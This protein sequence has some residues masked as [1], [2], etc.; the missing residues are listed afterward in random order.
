MPSHLASVGGLLL[1]ESGMLLRRRLCSGPLLLLG[2]A[3]CLFYQTFYVARNRLRTGQQPAPCAHRSK[4][5][6]E[7]L[8]EEGRR[9]ISALETLQ[10]QVQHISE[11]PAQRRRAL[12]LT[13]QHVI[14]DTEIQLYQRV[15][16]QMDYE[17]Q[18]SRYTETS[19][20]V[21][22]KKGVSEW[23]LLLCLS[24][25]ETS[26]LR[27][28]S[29]SH[30][31]KHQRVN[32]LPGLMKAFSDAG[33]GLCHIFTHP[34]L[35][36]SKLPMRP[37]SCGP[38][39]RKHL[40]PKA[41]TRANSLTQPIAPSLTAMVNVYILVTSV[42]PLTSFLH[43]LSV[44]MTNQEQRGQLTQLKSLRPEEVGYAAS[45]Q[46]IMGHLKKVISDVLQAVAS[47]YEKDQSVKRCL[48]CY[49][50]LTFTLLFNGSL[51][52]TIIQVDTDWTFS[53]LSDDTF[54]RKITKDLMLEETLYF[55]LKSQS[56]SSSAI[57]AMSRE[58][59]G[60]Q[61]TF[62]FCLS[63]EDLLLPLQFNQQ[64]KLP[65]AFNLLNP[66]TPLCSTS[67]HPHNVSDLLL[68][69][70]C[71][72]ELQRSLR[73]N[74]SEMLTNHGHTLSV[75]A[76]DERNGV[77]VDPRLRQI[78][79]DPPLSMT[80]PFDPWIKEYRVEVPFDTVMVRLRPEP[81]SSNCHVHLDEQ[82][83]PS[84][85]N[86]PI[87]LGNNRI[88]ILV[89][90]GGKTEA[91]VMTIYT[92]HVFRE[93]RPSLPM[94]GDHVMCSF[95]QECGLRVQL[96]QPCGLEPLNKSQSPA[97]PCNSGDKAGRWVVPCLSCLDNRTCDWREI[98][99]LPDNCFYA[100]VDRP[101]LQSCMT[102]R[103]LLFFGDSTNRGMMYFLMER[104]NSSLEDW[105]KA[106]NTLVYRN[107]NGGRTLVSYSY[108][109]QFWLGSSQRPTFTESLEKLLARSQPLLNSWQ[110]VL[111]V[112]G[113]QWLNANHLRGI[114]E[115]LDR[116]GL[117]HILVVVKSLGM[118]FHLPVDG[119]RSLS[120]IEVQDLYRKNQNL[121]TTA[122]NYGYEVIDTFSITM[123]RYKEFLQG[124][125]ACHFHEVEKVGASKTLDETTPKAN[126]T[127][128]TRPEPGRSTAVESDH[129]T[130]SKGL[131][132]HMRGPVNQ[133]Y[134]EILLSRLC[135]TTQN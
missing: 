50:L 20:L 38:S 113:V 102:D 85:A 34:V 74:K 39:N 18:L 90:D 95:I 122:R 11:S 91:V 9:F 68:M 63:E 118:G 73:T 5:S 64:M 47:V 78:Y 116:K 14:T 79:T 40:F 133:V 25:S 69:T 106:H 53:T 17:V 43:D 33:D 93:S 27:R 87:G 29:F 71:Y 77:C 19:S 6:D 96:D 80:P 97:Q 57:E 109:P 8:W 127:R 31:Q 35:S 101:Q 54:D 12:V 37:Y 82:R 121:I 16:Q 52:P 128:S 115:L 51:T 99:W 135:P 48:L 89:M 112:G 7:V 124:R 83:G 60:C 1:R 131:F 119:I 98:S 88:S 23:S 61:R 59:G 65:G 41:S 117:G 26:C 104:V 28:V 100:L 86:F 56:H 58:Y 70:A 32:L 103:K 126:G 75:H 15:L 10:A 44:V 110:T 130:G 49:Q 129:G 36:K 22:P 3:L 4:H 120:L 72:Y 111:V 114:R 132:Y 13:G 24:T 42:N 62:G 134:S 125:C 107:L 66:N 76:G 108:Y 45:P 21:R 2:V 81:I 55:L 92:L 67:A 84:M 46:T 105:E 30:L 94:F 123:G